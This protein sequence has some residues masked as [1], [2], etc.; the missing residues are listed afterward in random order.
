MEEKADL[1]DKREKMR[2]KSGKKY[3]KRGKVIDILEKEIDIMLPP[4]F[5]LPPSI[6]PARGS[7]SRP[8]FV[9]EFDHSRHKKASNQE[10]PLIECS[11]PWL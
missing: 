3:D 8:A 5:A 9:S 2:D 10:N 7:C 6:S 1:I 4:E 11:Y